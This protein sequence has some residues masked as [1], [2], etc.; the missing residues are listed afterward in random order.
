LTAALPTDSKVFAF[1]LRPGDDASCLNLF[2]PRSP[3]VLGVPKDFIDRG[4]FAWAGSL[5]AT[6]GE[7]ENPW[8]LL[9]ARFSDGAVPAVGD[10]NTVTWMLH[11][12]LGEEIEVSDES[13]GRVKLRIVGL[14]SHSLF[15]GELLISEPRFLERFPGATGHGFFLLEADPSRVDELSSKLEEDL[16]RYGFDVDRV[17]ACLES[18]EAVENTYLSTFQ[19]LGWLGLL[20]GTVGLGAVLSRS[21]SERRGELALLRAVGY[22]SGAVAWIILGETA[23]LLS[24]GLGVGGA[25]AIASLI[26]SAREGLTGLSWGGIAGNLLVTF[27]VGLAASVLALRSALRAP[28]IPSLRKE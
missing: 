19:L 7:K 12:G 16:A 5:A 21:V 24:L 10:A 3:R 23:W 14:L 4:G 20:L 8:S 1:R 11:S 13:G 22:S 15:Q 17:S 28:L 25:S 27:A 2:K 6:A 18:Y 9:D 26:P